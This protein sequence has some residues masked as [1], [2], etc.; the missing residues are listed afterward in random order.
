MHPQEYYRGLVNELR[1][2]PSETEWVEFKQNN[3]RPDEIGEYISALANSAALHHKVNAFLIW[4]IKDKT[5]EVVGTSFRPK[6]SKCGEEELENWLLRLL[7]PKIEFR[8]HE[9]DVDG[10]NVCMLEIDATHRDPVQFKGV[11]YIRVGSYKKPLKEYREKE[12]ALWRLFDAT[13][14]ERQIAEKAMRGDEV[15]KLINYPDYFSLLNISLPNGADAILTCLSKDDLIVRDDAGLWNIT[16]LGAVLFARDLGD[17]RSLKRKAIRVIKYK[18]DSRVE[19]IREQIGVFGYASGFKGLIGFINGLLPSNEVIGQALRKSVPMFPE[20]AVREL[21]AN[22]LIHQ[23]FAQTGNGPTIEIFDSRMEITNPGLPLVKTERFLDSPPKSRNEALA[24][25]MRRIGIC[26]ERGSGID[27][28]VFQTE[29]YQ[30]P[31]PIFEI[32]GD[33]TKAVLFA[34]K[35]LKDMD[36]DDK[37][38]ACY[39][40]ACLRYVSR[41]PM[42]NSSLRQR[43]KVEEKN[44]AIISRIIGDALSAGLILQYDPSQGR[45]HARYIPFWAGNPENKLTSI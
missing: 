35:A 2:L 44:R 30:L 41:E 11:E 31:A 37:T 43:F 39:L 34:H 45:R 28:V 4:G 13:P 17:F 12:R 18:G 40:H 6:E 38:R 24:S 1:K 26:E 8:F 7:T 19:T 42:T 33:S 15:L 3:D 22:A 14:F 16:N 20:L 32:A 27:K 9:V 36:K 25:M 21:L 23:D 10:K 29:F 5:H